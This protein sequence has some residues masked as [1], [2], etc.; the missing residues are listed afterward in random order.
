MS[1][2]TYTWR[3]TS[4]LSRSGGDDVHPG[5]AF[6]PTEAERDAFAD[7]LEAVEVVEAGASDD[8]AEASDEADQSDGDDEEPD[9]AAYSGADALLAEHVEDPDDY[10]Q[11]SE[12]A[13]EF[14]DVPSAGLSTDDLKDRLAD[15]LAE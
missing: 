13:E 12:L 8:E 15:E 3:G 1:E 7:L 6:E 10:G 4:T 2:N 9:S 14:E 11:L 5:D